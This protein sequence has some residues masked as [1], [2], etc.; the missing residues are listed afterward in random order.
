MVLRLEYVMREKQA[1]YAVPSIAPSLSFTA[2]FAVTTCH[3]RLTAGHAKAK[4]PPIRWLWFTG[5]AL[6]ARFG[7]VKLGIRRCVLVKDVFGV[8]QALLRYEEQRFGELP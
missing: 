2:G 4:T 8:P 6:P 3:L 7:M 1:S 5:Y